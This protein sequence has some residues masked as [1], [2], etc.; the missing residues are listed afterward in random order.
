M[1]TRQLATLIGA[2]LPVEEALLAVSKQTASQAAEGMLVT[3]RSR[4]MEGYSLARSFE[5]YP[6]AFPDLY[7]GRSPW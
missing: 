3:V 4:V 2:G 6:K 7:Q 1:V 5:A